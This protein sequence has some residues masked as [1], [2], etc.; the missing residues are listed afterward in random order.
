VIIV[1]FKSL[2]ES[3]PAVAVRQIEMRYL[4]KGIVWL[5][6]LVVVVKR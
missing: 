3:V 2:I 4:I 5:N 6:K 1:Q